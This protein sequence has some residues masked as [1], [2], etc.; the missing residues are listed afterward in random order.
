MFPSVHHD[1]LT[2]LTAISS[3]SIQYWICISHMSEMH[4][5][6]HTLHAVFITLRNSLATDYFPLVFSSLTLRHWFIEMPT[7][8]WLVLMVYVGRC[9]WRWEAKIIV[10]YRLRVCSFHVHSHI[11]I[12]TSISMMQARQYQSIFLCVQC[13]HS[14]C[15]KKEKVSNFNVPNNRRASYLHFMKYKKK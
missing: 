13:P 5:H 11:I 2:M 14:F 12:D 10:V 6:K 8:L 9:C 1:D 4:T 15:C 7:R 3:T